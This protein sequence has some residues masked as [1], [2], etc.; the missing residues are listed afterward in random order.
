MQW[1]TPFGSRLTDAKRYIRWL[2]IFVDTGDIVEVGD[3]QYKDIPLAA[4]LYRLM[5]DP[6][7]QLQVLT[8]PI[9]AQV[10]YDQVGQFIIDCVHFTRFGMQRSWTEMRDAQQVMHIPTEKEGGSR[11]ESFESLLQRIDDDHRQDGFD[12]DFY[13]RLMAGEGMEKPENWEKLQRDWVGAIDER[14]RTESETHIKARSGAFEQGMNRL[15]EMADG[16]VASHGIPMQ[17]ALQAWNLMNGQWT[18]SEFERRMNIVRI[19]DRYPDIPRLVNLMGRKPDSS[20]REH[21]KVNRGH[22]MKIEHSAGSD[23]EGVTVGNDLNALLPSEVALFGDQ[24]MNDLFLQRYF[25][26]RLQLFRYKSEM[27]TPSRKLSFISASRRGPMIVCVDTSASMYGTPQRITQ[28]L[29]S[30]LEQTAERL[31]R[32]CFLIDFSVGIRPIDLIQRKKQRRWQHLGMTK[33]DANFDL[34]AIPFIGGGTDARN[35]MDQMFSLLETEGSTYVNADVLWVTDFMIP[36][37][38]ADYLQRMQSFKESGTKFYGLE[39]TTDDV[40]HDWAPYFNQIF[41]IRYRPIRKY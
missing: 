25:T 20:G 36:Q 31:R 18:E 19:Q 4:Y 28:S 38:S 39:I 33:E 2:E 23:I 10:F 40:P 6:V 22:Q 1:Y 41:K 9:R 5:N 13:E 34:G 24:R 30:L 11:E 21:L 16:Y 15:M 26:H 29:L 14:L 27:T 35:M 37:P 7:I 32:D 12:R 8:S 3:E 17:Q